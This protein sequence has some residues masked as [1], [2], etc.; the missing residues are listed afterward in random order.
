MSEIV[1]VL[2]PGALSLHNFPGPN[3]FLEGHIRLPFPWLCYSR[4]YL[5]F[6]AWIGWLRGGNPDWRRQA[7]GYAELMRYNNYPT[8]AELRR[9]A[10]AAGAAVD[11]L[12]VDEF[13]FREGSRLKTDVLAGLRR[14]K[15][16]R[17]ATKVVGLVLLQ[18]YMV[19]KAR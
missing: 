5:A 2:K 4:S 3:N 8:K 16:E 9:A 14:L 17:A 6:C 19:L 11:F 7:A 12:E 1:R 13:L 15:A 10:A 18:R